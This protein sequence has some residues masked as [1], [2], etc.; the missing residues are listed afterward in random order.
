MNIAKTLACVDSP[1][2]FYE[3][4]PKELRQNIEFR[5]SL[6]QLLATDPK[7][8][9][10]YL[11]LCR[12]YLPIIFSSTFWT[13]NPTKRINAPFILR[14]PAQIPA[15]LTLQR[16]IQDGQDVGINKSR[17]EGAS[18]ICC[19]TF[20]ANCLLYNYN[21]FI[22]GSRTKNYVDNFGDQTTL[23]AKIDNAF[24]CLPSWWLKLCGYD[25]NKNRKDMVLSVPG[26]NSEIVG[27]T[28]NENFSAGSRGTAV[29]LD[30]FGRVDFSVADSIEGSVHDVS[31]CTIYSSTH[32]LGN[33]HVFNKAIR[34]ET[35]VPIELLW[36]DNPVKNPG[37]YA[38]PEPGKVEVLDKEYYKDKDLENAIYL[39]SIHQYNTKETRVQF[40]ADGG[41]ELPPQVRK[42]RSPWHDYTQKDRMG[43]K[44][45]FV[46]NVWA[47]PLGASDAPFDPEILEEIRNTTIRPPDVEGEIRFDIDYDDT[48]DDETIDFLPLYGER[49]LKWWG[50]L[51]FG[52]PEQRHNYIIACDPS[53][54][55]GSANSAAVIYDCNTHEQV[56]SWVDSTTK[57]ED[58]ADMMV[59]LAYWVGGVQPAFLIWESNGGCGT[60]F[61]ERILYQNY[62]HAYTQRVEDSKTRKRTQKYGW[63][64][65]EATKEALLG[66]LGVALSGGLTGDNSY[67][68]FIVRDEALL[69]ELCDCVFKEKGKGIIQSSRA[70][71]STG[72]AERHGDR[73][74]A[75]GLC[76]LACKEQDPGEA[77]Y[78][79]RKPFGSFAYYDEKLQAQKRKE[80]R[81]M[82]RILF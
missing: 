49:R 46:C 7:A 52:R 31:R 72:A 14:E 28:T 66:E 25:K 39:S 69:D 9:Q 67:L 73:A 24:D 42:V 35:V 56:G 41:K 3:A 75:A 2:A 59:A 27:D 36:Y 32:W 45:D 79:A 13:F 80:R 17:E 34:K 26:T 68:S 50:P 64:S 77:K 48:I 74:I 58:F 4:I 5:I 12:E 63:R 1:K 54:G 44:R 16:C 6:H 78:V 47:T 60:N 22:V 21:H 82:R 62:Y 71:L 61:R 55:L 8:Q 40:I 76:V 19:K 65:T 38:V 29:L 10:V 18:E 15:V 37:L 20:V 57:A 81:E 23:F 70:D 33:N 43:N 11:Q 30:E 53:Y 51:P